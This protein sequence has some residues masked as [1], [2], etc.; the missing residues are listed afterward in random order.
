MLIDERNEKEDRNERKPACN[1]R[2]G[3]SG[4]VTRLKV[5]TNLEV[6][7]PSER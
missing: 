5:C 6:Y 7:R 4:A 3:A 1:G 2:F